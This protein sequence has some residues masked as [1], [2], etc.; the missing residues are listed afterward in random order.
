MQ[1]STATPLHLTARQV[2]ALLQIPVSTVYEYARRKHNPL[3]SIAI[4]RHPRFRRD[5]LDGWLTR[6]A[7]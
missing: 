6:S 3:P 1:Q 7:N 4:G 2:A 5:E